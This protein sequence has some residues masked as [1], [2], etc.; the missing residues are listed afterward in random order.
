MDRIIN[1]VEEIENIL[2]DFSHGWYNKEAKAK[3]YILLNMIIHSTTDG[4][5]LEKISSIRNFIDILYSDRKH[6]KYEQ[7]DEQVK[8]Y[9]LMD[10]TNIRTRTTFINSKVK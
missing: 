8:H 9:I 4:Y 3:I 5:I 6:E 1:A 2:Y 10:C 7:G